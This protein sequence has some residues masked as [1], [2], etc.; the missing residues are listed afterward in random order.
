MK[1]K[2]LIRRCDRYDPDL[3]AGIIAEG[4]QETG[5]VPKGR[6]LCK[7]NVVLAHPELFPHAFTRSEFLEGALKAA[8]T[9]GRDV[10]EL[11]VGERCGITVPTRFCFSQA[12]YPAVLRRQGA[13][14]YYFDES[15]QVPVPLGHAGRL[16]GELYMPRP[17]MD[18]DFLINLPKFKAHPW[19]RMTLSLKNF[20]GLQDDRHRLLD[21]N[22]FLEQ[23]IVDL[24]QVVAPGFI[25]IDGIIAGQKMMLTPD[26]FDLG[27]VVMGT[28]SCAVDAVG[29]HMVNLQPEQVVHL[30]LASSR[31]LGP[32]SLEEIE[33]GG[34]FP[35]DEV[36]AKT[37]D[38]QF[39]L[40]RVD[41]Y[42][43]GSNLSC[44]VGSF[45]EEHSSDYCWG[46][47]PGAL[48][49]A[50]HI[51]RSYYP[52]VDQRLGKVRYVVGRVEGPLNL[53]PDEKVLFAGAC[54]SWEG[55][56]DGQPVKIESTYPR[57]R[58]RQ[59]SQAPSNDLMLKTCQAMAN[60]AYS[61]GRRWLRAGGCTMSVADHVHYLSFLAGVN[62]PNFDRRTLL[63]VTMAYMQMRGARAWSR[64][65]A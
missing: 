1:H 43:A 44:T 3:I 54:T 59:A 21:H 55:E 11:A 5:A 4:M 45:P 12:G 8:K 2:V 29:C 17:V 26:P 52:G 18:C 9:V 22:T 39:C 56:I 49:E 6:V 46:G 51:L 28:N 60:C 41:D 14:A 31:G 61:R 50:V 38:F 48:Q 62:N 37:K 63:P 19:T 53:A 27:A 10:E 36:Q 40:E 47:C 24:N 13:K 34:D 58:Q 20:I 57:Y 35:L 23:K 15:R 33:L 25:A 16:R 32:L 64:L 65:S 42:F 30:K 7:P